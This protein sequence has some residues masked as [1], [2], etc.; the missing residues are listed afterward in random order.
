MYTK[1]RKKRKPRVGRMIL[2]IILLGIIAHNSRYAFIQYIHS[3]KIDILQITAKTGESGREKYDYVERPQSYIHIGELIL[4]NN[5]VSYEFPKKSDIVS[6]YN[7]KNRSYKVS[8]MDIALNANVIPNF[9]EMM[10]DFEKAKKIHDITIVSGYRTIADQGRVLDEKIKQLGETEAAKWAANPGYSEHHTGYAIDIGIYKDNGQSQSYTG[11]GKYSWIN[12]NCGNYGF[13]NRYNG[14]K[15][16][17]TGFTNEPWH[18]RF[19][20][21]PHANI[22]KN[23]GFCLEEYID[24]L[25]SYSFES[26]HLYFTDSDG[27]QYEIYYVKASSDKT[28]IP[29]SRNSEYSIS[30]N[31]V[32]GFIV[33]VKK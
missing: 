18:Y 6:V 17:I 3:L 12:E 29:I 27:T 28:N 24:Y 8:D 31:N 26:K 15:V 23:N 19:V 5:S 2:L 1:K 25:K 22:I 9:N 16:E 14:D 33:T 13:I 21:K 7:K 32:D 10:S 4:V 30:G 20:G 11:Y